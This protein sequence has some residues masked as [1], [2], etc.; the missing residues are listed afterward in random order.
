MCDRFKCLPSAVLGEDVGLLR[1]LR[2]VELGDPP[3]EGDEYGL[4]DY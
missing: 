2:I 4:D 3:P 1:M